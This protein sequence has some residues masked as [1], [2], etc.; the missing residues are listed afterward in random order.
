MSLCST[1]C[2]AC[3]GRNFQHCK[4]DGCHQTFGGITLGDSHRVLVG[5]Y[6]LAKPT[7]K[8][9]P[10][11]VRRFSSEEEVPDKWVLVSVGNNTYRC[12]TVEEMQAKGWRLVKD[13]W[14]GPETEAWW[15]R[16]K[17]TED[18]H[19]AALGDEPE[20]ED[21]IDETTPVFDNEDVVLDEEPITEPVQDPLP[22]DDGLPSLDDIL[23][24]WDAAAALL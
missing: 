3:T 17:D 7:S 10:G 4:V 12:L 9:R 16:D 8:S 18:Y 20:P 24:D 5:S 22:L 11:T 1:T 21:V 19:A 2:R 23:A 14:R 13:V 6:V 15:D